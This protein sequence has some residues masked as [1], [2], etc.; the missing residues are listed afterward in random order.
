MTRICRFQHLQRGQ[1]C[2]RMLKK[3]P[4]PKKTE[5]QLLFLRSLSC[6]SFRT[7]K[8]CE[9]GNP[10]FRWPFYW[11]ILELRYISWLKMAQ[12]NST[13]TCFWYATK[14]TCKH[15]EKN[16]QESCSCNSLEDWRGLPLI[17]NPEKLHTFT[18]CLN[19]RKIWSAKQQVG[20]A[21]H[22]GNALVVNLKANHQSTAV[23]SPNLNAT[24]FFP[25]DGRPAVM[26]GYWIIQVV[27][28]A[29]WCTGCGNK[30][31]L[32]FANIELLGYEV[33]THLW[34]SCLSKPVWVFLWIYHN[35]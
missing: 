28:G 12:S 7:L 15:A 34:E 17:A 27:L 3:S 18:R 22:S 24:G 6:C 14:K 35:S 32:I 26:C 11:I 1:T 20:L 10:S 23:P 16:R 25:F 9:R 29:N 13:W 4:P 8:P 31:K 19:I 2:S 30:A 5:D 33:S 21:L